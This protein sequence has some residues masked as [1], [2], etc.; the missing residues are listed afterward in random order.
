MTRWRN[1]D[2]YCIF[3]LCGVCGSDYAELAA[4]EIN[5]DGED[6]IL[7]IGWEARLVCIQCD[8][9]TTGTS[10]MRPS[11]T[12]DFHR[13]GGYSVDADGMPIE[14]FADGD[15]RY[16]IREAIEAYRKKY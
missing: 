15:R 12:K 2:P 9:G 13:S 14:N 5:A 6:S 3:L 4:N 16:A 8:N 1:R 7:L 11:F 10:V